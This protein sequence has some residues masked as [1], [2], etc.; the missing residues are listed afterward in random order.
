[1]FNSIRSR[2]IGATACIVVIALLINT[3]VNYLII[4]KFNNRAVES[5]LTALT[6]SHTATITQWVNTQKAMVT[7]LVPHVTDSDP[8]P[9]LTQIAEAG[10][11]MNVDIGYPDKRDISSDAS[12][13]P[14]GYD[15]TSRPW[16]IQAV[17][18]GKPRVINP[19]MDVTTKKLIVTV[20]APR[21]ENGT[22]LGVVE[23]D[24]RMDDV[25][26]NIRNI[27][28]T[29]D[30]FGMLIAADGTIMAHPND[31]LTLKPLADLAPGLDS[32]AL[33]RGN[34]S[35]QAEIDG[36]IKLLKAL[37]V[38]DSGWFTV[39]V[40]DKA[41]ATAGMRSLLTASAVCLLCLIIFAVLVVNIISKR[42]LAPLNNIRVAMENI[43]SGNADLTQRLDASRNDEVAA[44]ARAFNT[45][46]TTLSGV[47][48]SIMQASHAVRDASQEI[49]L[50]NQDLSSRTESAAASLQQTSAAMEQISST[51]SLTAETA[52]QANKEIAR[53][54]QAADEGGV[55]VK[56]VI[57][58]IGDIESA[59]GKIADITGVIESIAFQSN[60]LALN[61]SV[62]AAR[63][64]DL[65]K[66]F[67][68]VAGEVR[69]LASRSTQA[70]REIKILID[71][72][73][74]S[75]KTGSRQ[76]AH[77]GKT[78]EHIVGGVKSVTTMMAEIS[79]ATREQ[80]RGIQEINI[81]VTQLDAMVQQNAALVEE[82]TTAS[83]AV[84]GQAREL[85]EAVGQFRM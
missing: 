11:F 56:T 38:G 59:S 51:V 74:E 41:E 12:G 73:L 4:N 44:I 80:Q 1:M 76:V 68:V 21:I 22:V 34:G 83:A 31:A 75:I 58:A 84:Q 6:Q 48:V 78:M 47:M 13:I 72:T 30:S 71:S 27:K 17:E 62:E 67:A 5:T 53:T 66:G 69:N 85:A 81:A 9:L 40:M 7:S 15:P 8:V 14:D 49:A 39:V 37:P 45:F 20:A 29:P 82:S 2:V 19:Y 60:I 79:N 42:A 61:A 23:G 18:A 54:A 10:H 77:T 55:A 70:A 52:E 16:Y 24:I 64:G 28:P 57:H 46:I 32:K 33:L 26:A 36:Q 3:V 35:V 25:I 50:G 65:G 63:A 43:A